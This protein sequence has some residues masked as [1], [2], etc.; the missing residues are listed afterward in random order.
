MEISREVFEKQWRPRFGSA[1]P[2][3]MEMSFWEWMIQGGAANSSNQREWQGAGY[4]PYEA[5]KILGIADEPGYRPTWTFQRM[6]ATRTKLPDGR[7]ICVGGEHEDS[8]DPDFYIYNDVVLIGPD[9]HIEIYGYPKE[10]FPP[11]DFHSATPA[12][13]SLVIIGSIGY[14]PDRRPGFTPVFSLDLSTYRMSEVATIGDMPGWIARH[15]AQLVSDDLIT[16]RGGRVFRY[17]NEK[18]EFRRNIEDYELNLRSGIWRRTTARNWRQY[19]V[20]RKDR[21]FLV[22]K[23]LP[24]FTKLVPLSIPNVNTVSKENW[25]GLR[26]LVDQVPVTLELGL[27]D[28]E[29]IIQGGL[30]SELE[31]RLVEEIQRQ[32]GDLLQVTCVA[33]PR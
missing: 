32:A 27:Y 3:R 15:E 28:I 23:D 17:R 12:G 16:I 31:R 24:D 29:I 7:V 22:D 20:F 26:F 10:V 9:G 5:R 11:T 8:Y 1:N 2:E 4:G 33:E 13:G 14:V 30:P 18:Q 25:I 19:A 21:R 6:G